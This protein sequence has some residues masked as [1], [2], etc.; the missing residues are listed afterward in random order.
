M[1]DAPNL[2]TNRLFDVEHAL[3]VH[4]YS[5]VTMPPQGIYNEDFL[6][7]HAELLSRC[8]IYFI[9][10]SPH[11]ELAEPK[12]SGRN[13]DIEFHV[14]GEKRV[15]T[16]P[17][18]D[19][20]NLHFEGE[21]FWLENDEGRRGFPS[22]EELTRR[23]HQLE[24]LPFDV[25]Y[26]GQAFGKEGERHAVDRL[27]N[28]EK[29][30]RIAIEEIPEGK[31][32]QLILVEIQP[33]TR[34]FTV[35]NPKADKKDEDGT[36]IGMALDSLFDTTEAQQVSLYEAAMIRYFQ[37]KFNT[38]FKDSFP[39]TNLKVLE[40]CYDKDMAAIIAE[41]CIDDFLYFLKSPSTKMRP[42]HIAA[43]NIHDKE[44]RDIFFGVKF[45][46]LE[47]IAD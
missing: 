24:P 15:V 36:R 19:K 44:E 12:Q 5:Y 41:F 26:I 45:G 47:N 6:R 14:A 25:L 33:A 43:Y 42:Y 39:S 17:L 3:N 16:H 27:I 2:F 34:M 37:P 9:G 35:F 23:L 20:W 31:R 10:Y 4:A 28:H 7:T 13:L 22:S 32:L 46:D 30:Q 40:Q 8:H 29:L 11:I 21:K 18:P 38:V 1:A